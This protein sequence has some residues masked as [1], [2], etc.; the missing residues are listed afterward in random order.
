MSMLQ[1]SF[2]ALICAVIQGK[3]LQPWVEMCFAARQHFKC[4]QKPL[5]GTFCVMPGRS[6][7]DKSPV[8]AI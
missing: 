5:K 6:G 4:L 7:A 2:E 8:C 3:S 1:A